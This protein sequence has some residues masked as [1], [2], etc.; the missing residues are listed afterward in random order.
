MMAARHP[1]HQLERPG[2]VVDRHQPRRRRLAHLQQVAQVAAAV[3]GAD[4]AGAVGVERLVAAGVR[5]ALT[6]KR[7]VG[8]EHRAVAAEPGRHARSRTCRRRARWPRRGRPGRRRPS[9]SGAGRP[10]AS[11][12]PRPSAGSISSRRLADRQPADAVA[13]EA[14]L[15]G[16]LARSRRAARAR[17]RPARCRTATGRR[18]PWRGRGPARPTRC[19]RSTAE[20]DTS[21]GARQRRAHVE[22]HLDVGAELLLDVDGELGGEVVG[23]AVVGG[24]ERHAVV[25]DL[26]ARARTP[27]S[28][29]SR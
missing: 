10:A 5:A 20:P 8:R 22:H 18:R 25:V 23:R 26:R 21:G 19:V 14:D 9:G 3:A 16:A 29:P 4:L 27:G 7:P 11:A 15:D 6:W 1:L 2:H 28:R 13:V 17:R 24:A 12:R